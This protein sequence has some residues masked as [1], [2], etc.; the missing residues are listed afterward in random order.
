MIIAATL[1]MV[2]AVASLMMKREKER[3]RLKAIRLP[4]KLDTFK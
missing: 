1:M 3:C 4:I 2:A